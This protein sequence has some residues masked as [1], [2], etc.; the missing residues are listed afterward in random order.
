[1]KVAIPKERQVGEFRVAAVPDTVAKMVAL[2]LSVSVQSGAGEAA[3]FLD[4]AF[5]EAGAEVVE[6]SV[7]LYRGARVVLRV[8]PPNEA[9]I[10]QM[11]EGAFVASFLQL[12]RNPEIVAQL[13][14]RNLTVIALELLPRISRAQSMDA[15]SSQASL[16]GYK[17]VLLGADRLGRIMAMQMTAA[18]TLV[19]SK[20]FVLGAGVAGLQAVATAKRLG[21]VVEAF[22]V[23]AAVREEV[24]SLGAKFVQLALE[25]AEGEGGYAKA[26]SDDFLRR[27]RE[28]LAERVAA[29]DLV[30]TT[31]SIPMGRAPIL[32]SAEMIEAMRPGSVVVDLAAETGGN[33]ELTQP[34]VEVE[35]KGVTII[36][37]TNLASQ[38]ATHASQ[39]Y[40]R[41]LFNLLS[42]VVKD[43]ELAPDFSDEIIS[44]ACVCRDGEVLWQPRSR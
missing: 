15:L 39:T 44:A 5:K 14:S 37:F 23:R 29:S 19:P 2:G 9:E 28:L 24:E 16:A 33:T 3:R 27:Q 35:H 17:A 30:I 26:Q 1:M 34:G 6:G 12:G 13:A 42:L 38:L 20:V 18:G 22:D 10:A 25:T 40:A 8:S 21:A 41:N 36:G 7:E 4:P 31:A 43:G 11:P 32:L